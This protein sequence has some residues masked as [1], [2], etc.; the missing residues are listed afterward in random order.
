MPDQPNKKCPKCAELIQGDAKKCKHCQADLRSW[1]MRHKILTGI[2]GLVVFVVAVS[3]LGSPDK[4]TS[5]ST[6]TVQP[7]EVISITSSQL[8]SEYQQNEIAADSKYKDKTLEVT[9]RVGSI[10]ESFGKQ[11]VTLKSDDII[12]TVQCFLKS[13]EGEKAA[14]L[15]PGQSVTLQGRNDGMSFNVTLSDCTIK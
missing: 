3:A 13:S 5:S 2:L 14:T 15:S 6:V 11:Y 9:G 4:G 1:F 7:E 12:I 8:V 10:A